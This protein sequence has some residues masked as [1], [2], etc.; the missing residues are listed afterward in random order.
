MIVNTQ[1]WTYDTG[2]TT[3]YEQRKKDEEQ[4]PSLH[5]LYNEDVN[6]AH[7]I[8]S[9]NGGGIK[10]TKCSAWFCY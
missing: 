3:T 10:C 5:E 2:Y 9:G 4:F 8:V 1:T 7:H 6:C